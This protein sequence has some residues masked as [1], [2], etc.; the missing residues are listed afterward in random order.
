MADGLQIL[1]RLHGYHGSDAEWQK[2]TAALG[3]TF[4]RIAV[5]ARSKDAAGCDKLFQSA[6]QLLDDLARAPPKG[7]KVVDRE[8]RP[9]GGLRVWMKLLDGT[10]ADAKTARSTAELEQLAYAIADQSAVAAYLRNDD[11]WRQEAEATRSIALG[12]ARTARTSDLPTAR[13][14]LKKVYARCDACHQGFK[15]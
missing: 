7:D 13:T 15:Q 14:E 3:E 8:F 4:K 1:A 9:F 5:A 11:R 10:Y 6:E 12:A 2:Q